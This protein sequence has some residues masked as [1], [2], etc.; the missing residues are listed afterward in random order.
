MADQIDPLLNRPTTAPGGASITTLANQSIRSAGSAINN[1]AGIIVGGVGSTL[2]GA[3]VGAVAEVAAPVIN[4]ADKASQVYDLLKNPTLG[5]VLA[6]AGNGFPPYR[7]ELDQF[8]SYSPIWQ[9]GAL[10]NLEL[11]NP[12]S[13]KLLGPAVQ[14][15]R[16]GGTGGNKIPTIY[17]TGGKVEMFIED[18]EIKSHMSPNPG[19]RHS[20]ATLI[21]FKVIE[22][23]SMGQ[24]LHNLRT[25]ALVTGHT[26]YISAPY[27]LRCSFIGYDDDGN[28]VNPMFSTR[29]FPVYIKK[30]NMR[31]SGAGAEYECIAVPCNEVAVEDNTQSVRTNITIRGRTVGEVLQSGA[32]SLTAQLNARAIALQAA[33]QVPVA[34]QYIVSFPQ[35]G[36]LSGLASLVP[37]LSATTG[38]N[39]RTLQQIYESIT[40]DTGGDIPPAIM[41]AAEAD[42]GVSMSASALGASLQAAANNDALWNDIGKARSIPFGRGPGGGNPTPNFSVPNFSETE[43]GSGIFRRGN[44]DIALGDNI[45][46]TFKNATSISDI[47]EEVL[48]VS[49]WGQNFAQE[50]P[51]AEGR[52]RYFRIETQ[53]FHA[54]SFF[55]SL[56]TGEDPRIYVYRVVPYT[57][58]AADIQGPAGFSL[59]QVFKQARAIKAY[60]YI[61]TGQNKDII[62]FD[63]QFNLTFFTGVHAS[64]GQRTLTQMLGGMLEIIPSGPDPV[65]QQN[66][67]VGQTQEGGTPPVRDQA[68]DDQQTVN[69]GGGT[70][71]TETSVARQ[72]TEQIINTNDDL[73]VCELKIH[74]DPF[75][76]ADSGLGNIVGIPNPLNESITVDGSMNPNAGQ[77]HIALNFRT[78]IDI[79]DNSGFVEFPLGGFLPIAMFSGIYQVHIVDSVFKDGK[80]E[81]TLKLTRKRNQDLSIES[82]ASA[83]LSFAKDFGKTVGLSG[84]RANVTEPAP[85]KADD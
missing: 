59:S 81:Q 78:P 47:I 64:R 29:S 26:N 77:V 79:D 69:G 71:S 18:V 33:D 61:Y 51:D 85:Q 9:L 28:V 40:G 67:S 10:T 43:P 84:S 32:D 45:S 80:F 58:D 24:F 70:E 74:G 63:L 27:L 39:G 55:N 17:E 7:N 35:T 13:F 38:I 19:T 16:S 52:I 5:G 65:P 21:R 60:N 12:L 82:L 73:L 37:G 46:F 3:A 4:I 42:V 8:A 50:A 41:E 48:M 14:I 30:V 22:P 11:N 83:A 44:L 49:Q 25:A 76:L 56:V 20:N 66:G 2:A 31:V 62:D 54:N 53:T 34:D 72:F 75:Y 1:S 68:Q 57:V 6:L 36:A 23:Y 15:L